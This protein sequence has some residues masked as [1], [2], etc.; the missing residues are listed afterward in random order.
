MFLLT[1]AR[2]SLGGL[3]LLGAAACQSAPNALPG[4]FSRSGVYFSYPA[5]WATSGL[6]LVDST[7]CTIN[8]EKQ[9]FNTSGLVSISWFN[10]SLSLREIQGLFREQLRESVIYKTAD[11]KFQ[12][13]QPGRYGRYSGY[14]CHYKFEL[15][16]QPHLGTIH[17]FWDNGRTFAILSQQATEDTTTNRPGLRR[18]AQSLLSQLPARSS[19]LP[20][21]P[22]AASAKSGQK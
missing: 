10:D 18:I 13:E 6:E 3:L 5:G 14:V 17:T 19:S 9:G 1:S 21:R 2:H 4:H 8:C 16:S 20:Q 12:P 7:A 15:L 22:A 11:I